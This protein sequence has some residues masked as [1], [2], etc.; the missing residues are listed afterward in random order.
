[1]DEE[2]GGGVEWQGEKVRNDSV[3]IHRSIL[4]DRQPTTPSLSVC[5][6]HHTF[7]DGKVR[8]SYPNLLILLLYI[9]TKLNVFQI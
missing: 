6:M 1:M 9:K 3:E 7:I 4:T 8:F 5:L 2:R